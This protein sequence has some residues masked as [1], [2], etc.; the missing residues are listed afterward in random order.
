MA[1]L[2]DVMVRAS[3][4]FLPSLKN[5]GNID[6]DCLFLSV[7]LLIINIGSLLFSGSLVN[8]T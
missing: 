3:L 4:H 7:V 2:V 6:I 8:T 5:G 1:S